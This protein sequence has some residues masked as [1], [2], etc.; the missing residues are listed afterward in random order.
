[1]KS[2]SLRLFVILA[3]LAL[4]VIVWP[5]SAG[6][7]DD[8]KRDIARL[9]YD[10]AEAMLVE[11]AKSEEGD[12]RQEALYLLAGLKRSV[13][14]AEII[15]QEVVQIE[16]SN[17]WG[18]LAQLELAKIRY[19]VGDYRQ[20]FEILDGAAACRHSQ[21]AC[22]FQGLSAAMMEDY[23]AARESLSKIK[24]GKYRPWAYLSLAEME[25]NLDNAEEACR[26]YRSM[27]RSVINP[28]AMYRY[29]E[30]LEQRGQIDDAAEVFAE[31]LS[32]FEHTPEALLAAEKLDVIRSE[33]KLPQYRAT[34]ADSSAMSPLTSG[35]TI[36]FGAFHDRT[37]ALKLVARLKRDLPGVRVDSDLLEF[38]EVHRVRFGYFKTRAEASRRA[39]EISEQISEPCTI[40]TLP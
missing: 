31:I 22:F 32:T 40:M 34:T 18:S 17:R 29:G 11:L 4:L 16:E 38:K 2:S 19:A 13:S 23:E 20:A 6:R 15:Y 36:Q 9:R 27:A 35:Y 14:E 12:D 37:N 33:P 39:E 7:I 28:T 25:M 3:T 30:C 24:G 26:R 8:A 1:M 10:E 21:E 5:A